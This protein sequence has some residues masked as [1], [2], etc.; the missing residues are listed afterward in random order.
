MAKKHALSPSDVIASF[1]QLYPN[2]Q[3]HLSWD[4][5]RPWTLLFA[6]IL[7]A[8]CTD[9]RVN[10]TTPTLFI[11]F[12][13][14]EAFVARPIEDL[15]R[16][17]YPL[18]FFRTKSKSLRRAAE[19]ILL[20][21]KGQLPDTMESLMKLPGVGRKTANVVL[22]TVFGKNEGFVVDTHVLKIANRLG[23]VTNQNPLKV[24]QTLMKL[25][26]QEKWAWLGH[27]MVQFGRDFCKAP[28]PL[29]NSCPLKDICPR[30]GVERFK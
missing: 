3:C 29:C 10:A 18:G 8:Q 17:L 30:R 24:E 5:K 13:D 1:E 11:Q 14:L 15:E 23:W 20:E 25:F 6:V 7:S 28:T 26:P 2:E 16:I 12:P 27:C 19:K 21:Y 4:K 22:Q 9:K